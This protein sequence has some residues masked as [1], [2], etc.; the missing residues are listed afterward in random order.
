MVV[1][2]I[3]GAVLLLLPPAVDG[4]GNR[5][6]LDSATSSVVAILTAAREQAI[7]DGHEVL[8]QIDLGDVKDR[9]DTG[10]MRFVVSSQERATPKGLEKEGQG[11]PV[12]KRPP[13]EEWI[14]TPWRELPTGVILTGY[15]EA[16]SHW[17]KGSTRDDPITVRFLPDGGVRPPFAVRIT[18]AD[19]DPNVPRMTTVLL[20]ALTSAA[21]V[22]EGEGE[23]PP[24]RDPSEFH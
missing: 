12:E 14:E 10:A 6:R 9:D 1:T 4:W 3:L 20:N 24:K 21:Y 17:Q 13:E 16:T 19:L 5:S 18:S 23:L 22:V 11:E 15:S 7:I 8:L 2:A